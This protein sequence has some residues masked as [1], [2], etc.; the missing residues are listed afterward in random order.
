VV[1]IEAGL[2]S[3]MAIDLTWQELEVMEWEILDFI[4]LQAV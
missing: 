2:L 3:L 1:V 4:F